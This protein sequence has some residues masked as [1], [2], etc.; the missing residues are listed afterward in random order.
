MG[1]TLNKDRSIDNIVK[2]VAASNIIS[3]ET[4]RSLKPARTGPNIMYGL[5]KVHK[6]MGHNCP[7]FPPISSTIKT[8]T[9]K[10]AKFLL[11]ILKSLFSNEYTVKDLFAF[12]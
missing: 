10:L 1:Y 6:Y 12:A 4:K 5:C 3:E 8:L 7:L 11:T 9:Y 2:Q